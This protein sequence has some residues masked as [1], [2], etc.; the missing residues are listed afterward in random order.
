MSSSSLR[1]L[2]I[3]ALLLVGAVVVMEMR[4]TRQ[5]TST[6]G[7]LFGDLKARLGEV[8]T[9]TITRAGDEVPTV[10]V[11]MDGRWRVSNRGNYPAD[12]GTL[13]KVLL[14]MADA[15]IIEAK[16]ADPKHYGTLE[17]NDPT[18][19]AG[20]AVRVDLAG[21]ELEY[22]LL[23]GKRQGEYRYVR[24]PGEAQTWLIDTDPAI[25]DEMRGWLARTI[26]DMDAADIERIS[27]RHADGEE[28]TTDRASRE[29]SDFDVLDIPEGRALRP[30]FV[31]NGIG[32]VLT[33]LEL[34]DVRPETADPVS[35]TTEFETFDGLTIAIRSMITEDGSWIAVH[36]TSEDEASNDAAGV[37]NTRLQGWQYRVGDFQAGQLTQRW[38]DI[39]EL[40][41]TVDKQPSSS[42]TEAGGGKPDG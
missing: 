9:V 8:D 29:Q 22:G 1:N 36:A 38:G 20:Q 21:P 4:S 2:G 31:A 25:P 13:R 27:I 17:L 11:A 42:E 40:E 24:T 3:L 18:S 5:P 7:L 32:N 37:I 19:E 6:G 10:L 15:Q 14:T 41:D 26:V 12:P 39:L 16:T 35:V 33:G 23:I 34:E 30:S 28:I